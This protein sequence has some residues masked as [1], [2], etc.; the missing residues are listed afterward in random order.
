LASEVDGR[1]A[2]GSLSLRSRSGR[3]SLAL[4]Y[5]GKGDREGRRCP[6]PTA[7]VLPVRSGVKLF[8]GVNDP[9]PP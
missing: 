3:I 1:K 9:G 2:S 6:L 5:V 8:D 4:R 7:V